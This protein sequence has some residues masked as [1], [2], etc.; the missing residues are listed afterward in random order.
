MGGELVVVTVIRLSPTFLHSFCIILT[1]KPM[2]I[3]IIIIIIIF[4]SMSLS[5]LLPISVDWD[6]K[7]PDIDAR[8]F[9]H[10]GM[11]LFYMHEMPFLMVVLL[12]ERNRKY[13]PY[14]WLTIC[15]QKV[16]AW[17]RIARCF[18]VRHYYYLFI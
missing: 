14:L 5:L 9:P 11:S 3:F 18:I 17:P 1:T 12:C 15:G 2:H 16:F 4:T 7:K 10:G 13:D 8:I 6:R